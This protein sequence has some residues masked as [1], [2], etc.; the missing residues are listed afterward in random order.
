MLYAEMHVHMD[1][2]TPFTRMIL[3]KVLLKRVKKYRKKDLVRMIKED[4]IRL[5]RKRIGE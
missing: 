5:V 2:D 4:H 3:K 1:K